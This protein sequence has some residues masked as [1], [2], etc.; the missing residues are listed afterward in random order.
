MDELKE[1]GREEG[2]KEKGKGKERPISEGGKNSRR[3]GPPEVASVVHGG[4]QDVVV[5]ELNRKKSLG[6]VAKKGLRLGG[7]GFVSY[8]LRVCL[9]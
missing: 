6:S 2:K 4:G 9:S 3:V 1:G 7:F 8:F 5:L